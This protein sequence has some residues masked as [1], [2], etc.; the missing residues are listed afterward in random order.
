MLRVPRRWTITVPRP[1]PSSVD[2]GVL[3]L[4]P[5]SAS[6]ALDD[7][8]SGSITVTN[9][10]RSLSTPITPRQPFS[11]GLAG[12]VQRLHNRCHGWHQGNLQRE[13]FE[14]RP[15]CRADPL[16]RSASPCLPLRPTIF[17]AVNY[18][19]RTSLTL[20]PGTYVGGIKISGSGSVCTA[21]WCLLL[22]R[23]GFSLTGSG[24]VTGTGVLLINAP[25]KSTDAI[26]LGGSGSMTSGRPVG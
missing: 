24:S 11:A 6:G 4:D 23:G 10:A 12:G 19:G 26:S 14:H 20:S 2:L 8:G 3:L 21:A 7:T 16:T 17:A 5:P 1:P 9:G 13:V 15:A 22:G 25:S 18:S